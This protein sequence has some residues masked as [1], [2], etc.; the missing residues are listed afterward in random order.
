MKRI[1]VVIMILAL[2]FIFGCTGMSPKQQSSLSGAA[3]GA[4][5]GG[6]LNK[7]VGKSPV[8]GAV[9]GAGVGGAAGY[10]LGK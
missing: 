7:Q 3:I 6:V 10:L 2:T 1:A 9:V 8:T 5:A 4:V